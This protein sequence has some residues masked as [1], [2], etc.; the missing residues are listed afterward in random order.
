[1]AV[2]YPLDVKIQ[3][4]IRTQLGYDLTM[5]LS[6][7]GDIQEALKKRYGL[8]ADTLEKIG[9]SDSKA[10]E[11]IQ[12]VSI[13]AVEDIEKQAS[14]AS[15]I[16]LVNQII[17]EGWKK[18]ATDIHIEPF[19]GGV[20]F[21]YRIDGLLYD[22]S[23]PAQIKGFLSAIIS[24]IKIMSNLNIVERRLPQDGR[25][26]VK[27]QE[28][29][30][31]LRISTIPT[32]FGESIVIRILPA[33]MLYSLEKLGLPKKYM[34]TFEILIQKPHGIIFVTGPTG[35]GKTTTLYSC[36]SRINTRERKIIT[37]ED[38]I[39]YEMSGITQIQVAP[40]IGLD[41]ARG[42]RSILR[43][44][45]DVIMVGEVRDLETAEIAIRVA[46]TG[47]LVFSTL[48]TNDAVSGITRL[49]DI[50][51][52]PYLISSSVEAFIAQRLIRVICSDCRYEDKSAPLELRNQISRDLGL[53]SQDI[54]IYRGKGCNNCNF[55]GFF[56]RTAIYEVLLADD[57]I[58]DL[59]LKKAPANHLKRIAVSKGMQ[60]LRQDGWQKVVSGITTPEEVMKATPVSEITSF[61]SSGS[62][63]LPIGAAVLE[64]GADNIAVSDKRIFT[65]LDNKVNLIYKVL[66]VKDG[67]VK[68]GFTPEQF[69]VTRNISAGGLVFI[70]DEP[71]A[72]GA[73]LE[74]K[75]ELPNEAPI[76]CLARVVRVE[77]R[78]A[79][80]SSKPSYDTAICFLDIAGSQRSQLNKYIETIK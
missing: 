23:M 21:R 34:Q 24:R 48:H 37:I 3:D 56:G 2:A 61:A 47:H 35:S 68:R 22:A 72:I 27:V 20:N 66:E 1:A 52:E 38:P 12:A 58:K 17:L 16:N 10:R 5:V 75:I 33:S 29:V 11:R 79:S 18:R 50:G 43:H 74:L 49:T 77:E 63:E 19:R 62:G 55:T 31:D 57:T 78:Q 36:L 32:P 65:R 7:S 44:D 71:L 80:L 26:V 53:R 46:L 64:P 70:S 41:F 67:L 14:D 51:V 9:S 59:I 76:D 73:V 69:S 15:V 13:E 60:T 28:Q 54:S 45:P 6:S 4:E 40:E 30:L 39:E 25:S 42:L 8:G